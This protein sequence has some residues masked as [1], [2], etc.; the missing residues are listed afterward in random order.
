[1]VANTRQSYDVEIELVMPA[2]GTKVCLSVNL[3]ARRL[4]L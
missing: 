4:I 3:F 1:M 2:T